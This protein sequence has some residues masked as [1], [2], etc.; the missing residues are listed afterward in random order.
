[1]ADQEIEVTSIDVNEIKGR[2]LKLRAQLERDIA[3]K[4]HQVAEDGDDLDPERGGVSNHMADDANETA[5]QETMLTL[6]GTAERQLAHVNEAL[7][8]IEDG[9]YGT[10]SNCGKPINPARLDALPF[11]TLCINCQNLADKGRI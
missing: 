4:D 7:E 2:L 3:I 9:S 8:R 5:E 11:S 1:M 6:R 10:C